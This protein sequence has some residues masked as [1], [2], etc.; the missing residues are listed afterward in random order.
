MKPVVFW[1]GTGQC[2]VLRDTLRGEAS[3]LAVFDNLPIEPPFEDV[4]VFIGED[5]FASWERSRRHGSLVHSCVAIGG[6]R[7]RDRLERQQWLAARGYSPLTV[8]HRRA[9]VS[10]EATLG[11]GCQVL[12]NAAVCTAVRLGRS[13]IVNTG[14]SVDH[15]CQ[16]GDG[17]HIGPGAVLAGGIEIGAFA[18]VGA[19]AVLLPRIRIGTGAIVG[20]G[21]VVTRNVAEGATVVGNP[22]RPH[23]TTTGKRT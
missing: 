18:F 22:A 5:G 3:L 8:V 4:P 23:L 6:S 19:G 16:L 14:A 20:A 21:A 9:F 1:G 15:D 17:V 10:P 12:A 7:G 13:V 2:K 11:A